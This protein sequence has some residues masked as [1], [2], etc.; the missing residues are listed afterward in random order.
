M[1]QTLVDSTNFNPKILHCF[2]KSKLSIHPR[3]SKIR[4]NF[5]NPTTIRTTA[6]VIS[7]P[8]NSF[9]KHCLKLRQSSSY[10]HSHASVLVVG[11]TPIREI[12]RFQEL[13]G[14]GP[15]ILDSLLLLNDSEVPKG[16]YD[17]SV[18]IV[19]VSSIVMKKLSGLQSI[20][21][22]EAIALMR[23]PSSFCNMDGDQEEDCES[24]FPSPHR[25]LVLD[26]I[27]DPGNLGTLL[28]SAMAFRWDGVFLL[29]G[30]CDP[31][32]DKALRAAR[33]ASFQLPIVS[34]KWAHLKSLKHKFQMK[35]LAGHPDDDEERNGPL[36]LSREL[37]DVLAG[38]PLCLVLGSEGR[39]LSEESMQ[40]CELVS[41]PMAGEFE[42]LNV[43]VAGGIFL[44][45]LQPEYQRV[46]I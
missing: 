31:F 3:C 34:G 14:E 11:L 27:Q 1:Q 8:S 5:K 24:W 9:I 42:S 25:I 35:M 36:L 21:S 33:G 30:C 7:S 15:T 40:A 18:R 41:I 23:F 6:T 44:F 2:S 37:A 19:H 10:R 22:V 4:N 26:G 16:L 28:R 12:S 32:N 38:G 46:V 20:D 39:G 43:S 17:P 45:M 29:P 13:Q